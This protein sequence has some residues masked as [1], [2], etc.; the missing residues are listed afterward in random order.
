MVFQV[1]ILAMAV[2]YGVRD[3]VE[4]GVITAVIVL[5]VTIGFFQEYQAEQKMESLRALSS[6]SADV[7]R[8]GQIVTVPSAEVVPGDIVQLK[9]GDTVP[10]DL[11]LFETMN[12][13]CDEKI[14]TG[15]AVPVAKDGVQ[16]FSDLDES[17]T[18]IGDRPN[19]AYSSSTVTKGRGKGIV[20]FTG[21]ETEIGKIAQSLSGKQRKPG[22]SLSSKE[23]KFQPVKG[24]WLRTLDAIGKFLGLTSG[25][26][27]QR[28]L[29]QLAY[30][31]FGCALILAV[32]VFGVNN[33]NVTNEVAVYAISTG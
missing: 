16:D 25:T 18:A 5:N 26:K 8:D 9:T 2:S 30:L 14:L 7:L 29:N 22:R 33:F 17:R 13:E 4:A 10:A 11:R 1:L 23:N 15:E 24:A 31:L 6:P 12:L 32:I 28:K 19:M 27:L 21:M 20:A 3:W